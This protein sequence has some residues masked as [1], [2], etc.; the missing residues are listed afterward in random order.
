MTSSVTTGSFDDELGHNE[1]GVLVEGDSA[2]RSWVV[3]PTT[4]SAINLFEV[5][6]VELYRRV[7]RGLFL[8]FVHVQLLSFRLGDSKFVTINCICFR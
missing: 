3:V 4:P 1:G 7:L 5:F 2:W 6:V 8:G